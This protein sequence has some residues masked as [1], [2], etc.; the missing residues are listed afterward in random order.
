MEIFNVSEMHKSCI[1]AFFLSDR[2]F[3]KGFDVII[4]Q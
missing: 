4:Y 1:L 3:V 2:S